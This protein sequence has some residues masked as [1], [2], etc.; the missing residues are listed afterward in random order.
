MGQGFFE[1]VLSVVR[2]AGSEMYQIEW[3]VHKF[4]WQMQLSDAL[5][6]VSPF[7]CSAPV[8][9]RG[10]NSNARIE[11]FLAYFSSPDDNLC[12]EPLA[13]G[14]CVLVRCFETVVLIDHLAARVNC[15]VLPCRFF[16]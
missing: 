4:L 6:V 13:D 16:L 7:A 11:L 2:I 5:R 15:N 10:H 12:I 8:F 3:L 14:P 1:F 9:R